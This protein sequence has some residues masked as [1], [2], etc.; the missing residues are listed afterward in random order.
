MDLRD[1]VSTTKIAIKSPGAAEL[2]RMNDYALVRYLERH[3]C[4]DI[5]TED[6]EISFVQNGGNQATAAPKGRQDDLEFYAYRIKDQIDV[7]IFRGDTSEAE[8][9]MLIEPADRLEKT[10][11]GKE[12]PYITCLLQ[13]I[14]TYY[15]I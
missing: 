12:V 7:H 4:C 15:I 11:Y 5:Q 14:S 6:S 3:H 10:P 9:D 8:V 13:N 1:Q 2:F